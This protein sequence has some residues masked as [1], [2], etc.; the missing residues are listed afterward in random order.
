VGRADG[1]LASKLSRTSQNAD[2]RRSW[3]NTSSRSRR[4]AA[5]YHGT[6]TISQQEAKDRG[7]LEKAVARSGG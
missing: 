2:H 4:T 5:S 7:F 1:T 3:Q 6:S